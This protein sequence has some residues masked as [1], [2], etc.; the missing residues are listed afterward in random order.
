MALMLAATA[1][2]QAQYDAAFGNYWAVQPFYNPAATGLDETL[3]V[4]GAYSMQLTGFENAPATMYAG[5]DLP[6]FFLSPKHGLGVAFLNDALGLFSHKKFSLQ[7]AFHQPL[8]G[9]RLSG[10]LRV[11]FLSETFDG[12]KVDVEQTGDP[13]FP[14]SE[15]DGSGFDLDAGLR[16]THKRWYVG[17]SMLHITNP[18]IELGD[19]KAQEFH[20]PAS[21]YL[22]GGYNIKLRNPLYSINTSAIVRTDMQ[23]WRADLTARVGYDKTKYKLYGGLSYSPTNSVSMLL[24]GQYQGI[25]LGYSYEL[26]TTGI[27]ATSGSHELVLGYQ[28][29]LNIFKKGKNKHKSVRIL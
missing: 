21:Y 16:Y 26:F 18:T 17:F 27:G 12:S 6:L 24:G 3:N 9:G 15:A 25:T 28:M 7:Y 5:V 29:D 4:Q 23:F 10:G 11:G 20:I 19:E 13:A 22:T 14:T 8:W 2:M 1:R